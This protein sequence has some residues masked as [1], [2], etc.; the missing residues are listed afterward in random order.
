MTAQIVP[1]PLSADTDPSAARAMLAALDGEPAPEP[2]PEPAPG[3]LSAWA[4]DPD[5]RPSPLPPLSARRSRIVDGYPERTGWPV[6]LLPG[7]ALAADL[8]ARG[9]TYARGTGYAHHGQRVEV[10]EVGRA[11]A[12]VLRQAAAGLPMPP[13][14]EFLAAR[15]RLTEESRA[16]RLAAVETPEEEIPGGLG[17]VDYAV[18]LDTSRPMR[19]AVRRRMA[20]LSP[21]ERAVD[22]R[23][24][25]ATA[26]ALECTAEDLMTSTRAR[27]AVVSLIRPHLPAPAA[28]DLGEDTEAA[29]AWLASFDEEDVLRRST[30]SVLYAEAGRPGDLPPAALRAL[31]AERWGEPRKARGHFIYRPA[32][33]RTARP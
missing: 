5:A 4:A 29:S 22:P 16:A 13:G 9:Y 14:V 10:D 25:R 8:E 3:S 26:D 27:A 1:L 2:V 7:E 31:A 6:G 19:A 11:V 15:D 21:E 18:A 30:L 23:P 17:V 32:Q 20:R 28:E 12:D 24:R 33:A